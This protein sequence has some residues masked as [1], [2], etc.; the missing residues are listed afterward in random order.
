MRYILFS[1]M[2]ML[3]CLSPAWGQ[4][5]LHRGTYSNGGNNDS[6]FTYT[7]G[8]A[9]IGFGTV[10]TAGSI[11][12]GAQPGDEKKSSS[13]RDALT[14]TGITLF[15]NPTDGLLWVQV[16]A[17]AGQ[18]INGRAYDATGRFLFDLS[19]QQGLQSVDFCDY[20]AGSYLL[21]LHAGDRSGTWTIIKH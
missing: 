15:P 5:T 8:E 12:I 20:A 2:A 3:F 4:T 1:Y 7:L 17:E 21:Q 16:D 18:T 11:S 9:L 10:A 19:L 14:L 13:T 6:Q